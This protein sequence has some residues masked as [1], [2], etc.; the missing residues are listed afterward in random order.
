MSRQLHLTSVFSGASVFQNPR[1]EKLTAFSREVSRLRLDTQQTIDVERTLGYLHREREGCC[2]LGD[3]VGIF[4]QRE[5][6]Q[7]LLLTFAINCSV[8]WAATGRNPVP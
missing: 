7:W 5:L 4:S 2:S 3:C 8:A 6:Q 1:I